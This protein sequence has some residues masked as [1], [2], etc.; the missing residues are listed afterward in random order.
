MAGWRG[1]PLP[2]AVAHGIW[3]IRKPY[4]LRFRLPFS[5]IVVFLRC[6][7]SVRKTFRTAVYG[8]VRTVVWQGSAGERRPYADQTGLEETGPRNHL[9][10][11][12]RLCS[13]FRPI[14][15]PYPKPLL[16]DSPQPLESP[17]LILQ[18]IARASPRTR[19]A[20]SARGG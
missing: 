11:P 7:G 8:P 5:V 16:L 4:V 1:I 14:L 10:R 20:K 3:P 12:R 15:N 9:H 6:S 18:Q 13:G 19:D 17:M 2:A